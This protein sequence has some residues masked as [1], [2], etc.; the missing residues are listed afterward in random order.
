MKY[1]GPD[2]RNYSVTRGIKQGLVQIILRGRVFELTLEE[3]A[4]IATDLKAFAETD[5]EF[6]KK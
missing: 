6:W 2:E 5:Q 1:L 3:C 4:M